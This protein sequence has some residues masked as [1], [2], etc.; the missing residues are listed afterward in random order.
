[1]GLGGFLLLFLLLFQ[2]K[3]DQMPL[4]KDLEKCC[5]HHL[6]T[7]FALLTRPTLLRRHLKLSMLLLLI[8]HILIVFVDMLFSILEIFNVAKIEKLLL[9][10][11]LMMPL[12]TSVCRKLLII[13]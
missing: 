13:M 7:Y 1:M 8:L 4:Q 6:V 9:I 12:D 3:S 10:L 5:M 11:V 2:E